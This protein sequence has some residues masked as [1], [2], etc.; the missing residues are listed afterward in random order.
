MKCAQLLC[1][2]VT[3]SHLYM[4]MAVLHYRTFICCAFWKCNSA[5][6]SLGKLQNNS[7]ISFAHLRILF[8]HF[9]AV[10]GRTKASAP[11]SGK[12]APQKGL[13]GLQ[14]PVGSLISDLVQAGSIPQRSGL[15][16]GHINPVTAAELEGFDSVLSNSGR[17]GKMSSGFWCEKSSDLEPHV[18]LLCFALL[19][20][21]FCIGHAGICKQMQSLGCFFRRAIY[22]TFSHCLDFKCILL[23]E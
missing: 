5:E 14:G 10:R 22:V 19:S 8:H 11:C 7:M 16:G 1:F 4:H 23:L 17:A 20:E 15:D 3:L 9:P 13:S 18:L 2:L 12:P 21:V 6:V